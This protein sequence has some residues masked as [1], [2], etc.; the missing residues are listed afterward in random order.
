MGGI[1]L[2]SSDGSIM[3]DNTFEGLLEQQQRALQKVIFERL[4]ATVD[5]K[6]ALLHG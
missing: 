2:T 4:F 1:K 3:L 5:G 6:G